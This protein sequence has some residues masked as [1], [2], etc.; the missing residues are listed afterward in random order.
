MGLLSARQMLSA[1]MAEI[2]TQQAVPQPQ[3]H[4]GYGQAQCFCI[5]WLGSVLTVEGVRVSSARSGSIF[6]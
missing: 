2:K 4:L 5:G 6:K 3:N 1:K